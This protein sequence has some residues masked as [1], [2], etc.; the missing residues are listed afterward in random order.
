MFTRQGH[1]GDAVQFPRILGIEAVGTVVKCPSGE[2]KSGD[3]VFTAMGG[4]GR[5]ING[6]YAEYTCVPVSQVKVVRSQ[7]PWQVLGALP[8]MLQ[9]AYGSL[10][11]A[12][13]LTAGESLLVR[14]GTTSVGLAAAAIAKSLMKASLVVST[15]RSASR[16][17]LLLASGADDVLADDGSIAAQVAEKYPQKF[18]CVG[19]DWYS[20][21]H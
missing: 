11:K 19:I 17:E 21:P 3:I 8:E 10:F 4:L 18:H 9:T 1:S 6:S 15:T 7:L 16:R 14:G 20:H 12:L 2:L 5:S 13:R